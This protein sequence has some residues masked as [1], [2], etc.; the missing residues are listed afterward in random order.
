MEIPA[1]LRNA[2]ARS[3]IMTG[4]GLAEVEKLMSEKVQVRESQSPKR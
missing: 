3:L 4:Q 1:H 2:K